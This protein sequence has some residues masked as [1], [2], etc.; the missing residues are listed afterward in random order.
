[1][2]TL[3]LLT[4]A[5]LAAPAVVDASGR[6]VAEDGTPVSRAEVCELT[7][8]A[9]E[10]CVRADERGFYSIARTTHPQLLVRAKGFIAT[11]I[12]AAPLNEPV[13]LARAATLMVTIVDAATGKPLPEGRVMLDASSGQ[14]IGNFVPF[15]QAGVRISTLP[16]GMVFVRAE[17]KGY[18]PGGPTAVELVG[19][20]DRSV[21]IPMKKPGGKPH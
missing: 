19:G 1:M 18:K 15:N 2:W 12:D 10:R 8:G 6:I 13:K 4:V 14:R 16:P 5:W 21:T 11:M 7:Q 20:A 9:A 3:A 17:S